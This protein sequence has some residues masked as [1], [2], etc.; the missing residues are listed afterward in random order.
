MPNILRGFAPGRSGDAAVA[1][2]ANG[3]NM[4]SSNGNDSATPAP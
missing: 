3:G 1:A 2:R 4:A